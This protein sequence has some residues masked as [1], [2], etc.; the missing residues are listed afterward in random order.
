M[1]TIFIALIFILALASQNHPQDAEVY[2]PF[3]VA[4]SFYNL[5]AEPVELY[6]EQPSF[7]ARNVSATDKAAAL[8]AFSIRTSY[9]RGIDSGTNDPPI[10]Q[11]D[12]ALLI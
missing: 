10:Y 8:A 3:V 7:K 2:R 4:T 9:D 6:V 12:L 5:L 11:L 1:R